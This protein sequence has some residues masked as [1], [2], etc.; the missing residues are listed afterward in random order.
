MGDTMTEKK[1]KVERR[2]QP[3]GTFIL[4]LMGKVKE[5]RYTRHQ[6]KKEM[7]RRKKA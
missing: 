2:K 4:V 5:P 7:E 1:Y 6:G 3:D